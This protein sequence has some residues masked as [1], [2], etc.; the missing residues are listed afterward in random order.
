MDR[1]GSS[2]LPDLKISLFVYVCLCEQIPH[3]HSCELTNMVLGTELRFS[4]R[5]GSAL[6]P[7]HLQSAP[8][9]VLGVELRAWHVRPMV[10]HY[11]TALPRSLETGS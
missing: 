2:L 11:A 1:S 3:V 8:S 10:Y 5:A 7:N 4:A 9:T 6:N